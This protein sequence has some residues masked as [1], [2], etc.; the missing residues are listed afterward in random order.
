MKSLVI[1]LAACAAPAP[2][3][4]TP[5]LALASDLP[6]VCSSPEIVRIPRG[7]PYAFRFKPPA[8]PGAPVLV[9]LP[10]GPGMTSIDQVPE[11]LPAGWGYLLTDPRGVGCNRLAELPPPEF[12]SSAA[13][14]D[15]VIAAIDDRQLDRYV[16]YGISYGTLLATRVAATVD[17]AP[18]AVVMEGVLGRAFQPGEYYATASANQWT[19]LRAMMPDDV[20]TELDTSAEPYGVTSDGWSRALDQILLGGTAIVSLE[21]AALSTSLPDDIRSQALAALH[22]YAD[23]PELADPASVQLYR[24]VA[25]RE[26]DDTAPADDLDPLFVHGQLVRNV[27]EVGTKCGDLHVTE[28]YDS[29]A[30]QFAAPAYYFVGQRDIA[31][32]PSQG[33]YAFEHHTGPAVRVIS[34]EAGHLS[35]QLDQSSC[36]SDVLTS[37][38]SG[39]DDLPLVLATCP[40]AVDITATAT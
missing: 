26:I 4:A 3:P 30:Y 32:P 7:F 5:E 37:I 34:Q 11:F 2:P 21:L 13:F 24:G 25:C 28:P 8:T 31:T 27:A 22:M 14:T 38:A 18:S 29:A 19:R 17:R 9:Y 40:L 6:A 36:A 23:A 16:L 12:F 39:G 33:A 35:L 1:V 15:D 10:G 20:R